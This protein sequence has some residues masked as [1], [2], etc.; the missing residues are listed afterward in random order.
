MNF[1]KNLPIILSGLAMLVLILYIVFSS[2]SHTNQV[3]ELKQTILQKD[4]L[5]KV[6]D[7]EYTKLVNDTKTKSDLDKEVKEVS[8]DAY[9]DIKKNKEKIV[10]NTGISVKPITKVTIDTIYVDSSGTRRFTSYYPNR[11]SAFITHNTTINNNLATNK[12]DFK[13]LKLNVVVTQQKDGMYR[14]RLI[15]P[16]WIEAQE[17][18]V[19]SLPMNSITQKNFKLLVGAS[20]GYSFNDKDIVLGVYTGLRYKNKIILI[21]GETNKVVSLGYIQEF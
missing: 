11:D 3:D 2:I 20:G 21:H 13:P 12:W 18:T 5:G 10:N 17:V 9:Q 16:K 14:A 1:K 7:G 6:R 4:S 15:G 8:K 19:N